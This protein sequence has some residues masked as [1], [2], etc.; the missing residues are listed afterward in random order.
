MPNKL[1]IYTTSY[2]GS[3][4]IRF[5]NEDTKQDYA[6]DTYGLLKFLQEK[7]T[8]EDF[9]NIPIARKYRKMTEEQTYLHLKGGNHA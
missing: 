4:S 2:Y 8:A 5:R 1:S 9:K 7:F 6:I 3:T